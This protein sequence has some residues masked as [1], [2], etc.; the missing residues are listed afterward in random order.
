MRLHCPK[1]ASEI[2]ADNINLDRLLAKCQQCNNVFGFASAFPSRQSV[3]KPSHIKISRKPD[4][5]KISWDWVKS[6]RVV[7]VTLAV[8]WNS[9]MLLWAFMRWDPFEWWMM[10]G[11]GASLAIGI[12]LIYLAFASFSNRQVVEV[13]RKAISYR[14]EPYKI[15]DVKLV[16]AHLIDQLFTKE[17]LFASQYGSGRAYVIYALMR[18]GSHIS[19]LL[20]SFSDAEHALYIEQEIEAFLGIQGIFPKIR[21]RGQN[22]VWAGCPRERMMSAKAGIS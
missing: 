5:L 21:G 4:S 14:N 16:D 2:P 20:P 6:A 3:E 17:V 9:I 15:R 1:C 12:G 7:F 8:M 19:L 10:F 11:W 18:D 13:T 22:Q